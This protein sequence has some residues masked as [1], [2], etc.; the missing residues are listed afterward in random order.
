MVNDSRIY[1]NGKPDISV[2]VWGFCICLFVLPLLMLGRLFLPVIP[3]IF[4]GL[5]GLWLGITHVCLTEF[6]Q[7]DFSSD[8]KPNKIN[9]SYY[10]LTASYQKCSSKI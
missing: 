2:S 7:L 5:E 1:N 9:S 4:N 3:L 10:L 6:W 8:P